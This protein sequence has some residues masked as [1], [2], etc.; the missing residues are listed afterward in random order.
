MSKRGEAKWEPNEG[1]Q[2]MA[3]ES[4]CRDLFY[5]GAKG[6]GKTALL[7]AK[8]KRVL[9]YAHQNG[10]PAERN[11]A[12]LLRTTH[13]ELAEIIKEMK[14]QFKGEGIHIKSP[15]H[16][17]TFHWGGRIEL[18][19]L[20]KSEEMESLYG[21]EF[22][23]VGIDEVTEFPDPNP[24]HALKQCLRVPG[25]PTAP[26][27]LRGFFMITG[28]PGGK[29]H[30]WLKKMYVSPQ[31]AWGEIF[32]DKRIH[33]DGMYAQFLPA[34][35]GDNP[36]L[37]SE[38]EAAIDA[39]TIG[40]EWL[41]RARKEGEWEITPH[42]TMFPHYDPK[43]HLL[44]PFEIPSNWPI[45]RSYDWGG[46]TA[47]SAPYSIGFWAVSNGER[48]FLP[49][50]NEYLQFP[51]G[52]LIRIAEVWG[53]HPTKANTS[54]GDFEHVRAE[55]VKNLM[56]SNSTLGR[57][58][59]GVADIN[60]FSTAQSPKSLY[61]EVWLKEEIGWDKA[62]GDI[63]SRGPGWQMLATYL[64]RSID[65]DPERPHL[66]AFDTCRHF[67]RL[68]PEAF[69]DTNDPHDIDKETEAAHLLDEVRYVI[70][71]NLWAGQITLGDSGITF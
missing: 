11:V 69:I 55:K 22:V 15:K 24:I 51:Y 41:R 5:G 4:G 21:R 7:V 53:G 18:S 9:L 40:K 65:K 33:K 25:F 43:I 37:G 20:N 52:T 54:N 36:Y 10:V 67:S 8:A 34:R 26:H 66:Y 17:F 47:T 32:L 64:Q 44:T 45:V 23:F 48:V 38:Y 19:H 60:I 6:G 63:K 2:R 70:M 30:Y 56:L 35:M 16:T 57:A 28:N 42:A 62:A 39:A 46:A 31:P 59:E 13:P 61:N 50:Q 49:H 3:L 71:W 29:A 58:R 12:L 14:V 27:S 68:L 1:P